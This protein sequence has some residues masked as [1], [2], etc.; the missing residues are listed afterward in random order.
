[1]CFSSLN[2]N[3]SRIYEAREYQKKYIFFSNDTIKILYL[4]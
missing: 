4:L 3:C 1:M 2:F